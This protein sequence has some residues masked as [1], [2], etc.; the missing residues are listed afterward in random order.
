MRS[1]APLCLCLLLVFARA[2]YGMPFAA[3]VVSYV[4][5]TNA[6]AG[7]DDP[8][9]ALGA[10]GRTTGG[11]FDGDLTPFNAPYEADSIVSIGAGGELVVRFDHRVAD[12]TANA[13]GIDLLIFGNSFLTMDFETGLA[14]GGVFARPAHVSVSQDGVTWFDAPVLANALFPTLAFQN[15][16]G[17]FGLGGS[18]PTSYTLPVNPAL[19]EQDFVGLDVS[20]IAALYGGSGGG[21]GIDL[22]AI[23]LPWIEYVRVWQPGSD[24]WAAHVDAFAD[25][26]EPDPVTLF[27]VGVLALTSRRARARRPSREAAAAR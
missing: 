1:P 6:T 5:G 2:S 26:P 20:Q 18:D 25:V 21:A 8:S 27:C 23:G 19:T 4:A 3:E 22:A 24:G 15:P 13:Y 9:V 11:L 14:D 17:P 7:Y 10:P 16:N 12:D